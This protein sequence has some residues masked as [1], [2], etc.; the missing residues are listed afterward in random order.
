MTLRVLV[1]GGREF[2]DQ[3]WLNKTLDAIHAETPI[4]LIIEGG[5]RGA[6][7]LARTWAQIRHVDCK[8]FAAEW[9]LYNAAAGRIRNRKML[10]EGQPNLVVP[11]PGSHGTSDMIAQTMIEGVTILWP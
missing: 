2:R 1:C 8:T 11:F 6:D 9:D 3:L 7:T 5:A 10:K 4:S